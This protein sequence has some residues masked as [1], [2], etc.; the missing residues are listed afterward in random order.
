MLSKR[1]SEVERPHQK[2]DDVPAQDV[3]KYT[4]REVQH[5]HEPVDHI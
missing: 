1:E 4:V 5:V 3:T 2:H